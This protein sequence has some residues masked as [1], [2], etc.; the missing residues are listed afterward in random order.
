VPSITNVNGFLPTTSREESCIVLGK[1]GI[2][3][4]TADLK[5]FSPEE[6]NVVGEWVGEDRVGLQDTVGIADKGD[7]EDLQY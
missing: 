6:L 1:Q 5:R 2:R 7:R 4:S 3:K